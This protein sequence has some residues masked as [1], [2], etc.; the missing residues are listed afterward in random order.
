[1]PA[2]QANVLWRALNRNTILNVS[3]LLIC[4][5]FV[6]PSFAQTPVG[7]SV[8]PATDTIVKV[9]TDTP[10]RPV[11]DTP[12]IKKD[13]TLPATPAPVINTDST[14]GDADTATVTTA[15]GS[16]TTRKKP[17][18]TDSLSN[19]PQTN[20]SSQP[21]LGR[22]STTAP[23]NEGEIGK[24]EDCEIPFTMAYA[25]KNMS[26]KELD[27]LRIEFQKIILEDEEEKIITIKMRYR[28][29]HIVGYMTQAPIHHS[30]KYVIV[31]LPI[32]VKIEWCCVPDSTHPSKHCVTSH[33]EL[34]AT[35]TTQHCKAWV[36]MDDGT[37]MVEQ[38]AANQRKIDLTKYK[39]KRKFNLF[40]FLNVFKKKKNKSKLVPVPMDKSM[41]EI[42][43][44]KGNA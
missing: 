9:K 31:N 37:D 15:A 28:D 19:G 7:D 44:P 26:F 16:D 13:T 14:R 38:L 42:M 29:D 18:A 10:A 40:G 1:M 4:M 21:M 33:A 6:M 5:C 32:N 36:Q 11:A 35:D 2:A 41:D 8:K 20:L 24:L 27:T 12:V 30:N 25:I 43:N 22:S 39:K 3:F 23:V 34:I 17:G